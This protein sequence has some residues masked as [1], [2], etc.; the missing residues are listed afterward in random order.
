[1]TPLEKMWPKGLAKKTPA[2]QLAWS[3]K[4]DL[5][6]PPFLFITA[7]ERKAAWERTPP[8]A[9]PVE[10]FAEAKRKS[11]EAKRVAA[12]ELKAARERKKAMKESSQPKVDLTNM[13]WDPRKGRFVP[14]LGQRP[15]D[16]TT[17]PPKPVASS[18]VLELDALLVLAVKD[19]PRQPGTKAHERFAAMMKYVKKNAKKKITVGDVL[20]NTPYRKDDYM[21]DLKRGFVK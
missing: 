14:D 6:L 3:I 7:E 12:E 16:I 4:N 15:K 18:S 10:S 17:T 8:R 9:M 13:R 5:T 20:A 1:M 21:W 11:D 19:N 2:E